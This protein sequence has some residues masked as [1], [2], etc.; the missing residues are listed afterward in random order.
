MTAIDADPHVIE[1]EQTWEILDE[2]PRRL[3]NG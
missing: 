2:N 1:T 3:Y